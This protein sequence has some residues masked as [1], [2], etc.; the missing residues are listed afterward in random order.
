MDRLIG[1]EENTGAV[2]NT[3]AL[4]ALFKAFNGAIKKSLVY[5]PTHPMCQEARAE[6]FMH[7]REYLETSELIK[8]GVTRESIIVEG[9]EYGMSAGG[10]Y[11]G[12]AAHLHDRQI[13]SIAIYKPVQ[14]FELDAFL[15]AMSLDPNELRRR[16]GIE[17]VLDEKRVQNIT[18][19]RL[20]VEALAEEILEDLDFGSGGDDEMPPEEMYMLLREGELSDNETGK[21][22][23][24]MRQ[25]PVETA[26]MFVKLSDMAAT[27]DGDPSLEGR[28]AYVAEAIEEIAGMAMTG[29]Q[30]DRSEVFQNIA[31]G[32]NT[33]SD[34]FKS[35]IMEILEGRFESLDFGPE[36]LEAL[37][38]A[39]T[40]VAEQ[41]SGYTE[42]GESVAAQTEEEPAR[43]SPEE[44]YYEFAHF[45]DELPPETEALVQEEIAAIE[46]EDVE[47]E[48]VETLV[49][50]LIEREDEAHIVNA[51]EN[52]VT[53]VSDLLRGGRI[54]LA[55]K[56]MKAMRIK[57]QDLSKTSP[58]LVKLPRDALLKLADA[59]N[60][61][62]IIDAAT[63]SKDPAEAKSGRAILDM[64]GAGAVPG[65]LTLIGA[66]TDFDQRTKLYKIAAHAGQGVLEIFERRLQDPDER[67]A[68]A[69]V[70]VMCEFDEP[71]A[72]D[73][74]K[75]A[76]RH[77]SEGIR[78]EGIRAMT[79]CR[80]AAGA[81][82]I[83]ASMDDV[84]EHVREAAFRAVATL[85]AES[86]IPKLSEM[87]SDKDFFFRN[88][89]LRIKAIET[90]GDIG[91]P[92]ALPV[93]KKLS[94]GRAFRGKAKTLREAAAKAVNKIS[95]SETV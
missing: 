3:T 30:T 21:I 61:P 83:V 38:N 69:V 7:L 73:I 9:S 79:S 39:M 75:Q 86:A 2:A 92:A 49:E 36:L 33:L 53:A 17:D 64:L 44:V 87:A 22:I 65:L 48:A 62:L 42:S 94:S 35:P 84:S 37:N 91:S 23:L 20:E 15:D 5:S 81:P 63:K 12:L 82:L 51:L 56:A 58:E 57:G 40:M 88:L 80:G 25:S 34:D 50:M 47:R 59:E 71:K 32:L 27:N 76:I 18:A 77:D 19:K 90:L 43:L 54:E 14:N 45:Y 68:K 4:D 95:P 10:F 16:G 41:T 26:K 29:N 93:L 78:V 67:V 66:E 70:W 89:A 74:L 6:L 11:L 55:A 60:L 24:R 13:T 52:L 1:M 28:A 72:L 85:K 46:I 31:D 8:F